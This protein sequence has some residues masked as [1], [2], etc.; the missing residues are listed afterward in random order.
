MSRI[1]DHCSALNGSCEEN[2][3]YTDVSVDV[4]VCICE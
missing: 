4:N 3:V 1:C 2:N